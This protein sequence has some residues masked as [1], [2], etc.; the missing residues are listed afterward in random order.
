MLGTNSAR[1]RMSSITVQ[2]GPEFHVNSLQVFNHSTPA[3][4]AKPI[5]GEFPFSLGERRVWSSCEVPAISVSCVGHHVGPPANLGCELYHQC[6]QGTETQKFIPPG[7]RNRPLHPFPSLRIF[8]VPLTR[9]TGL[10]DTHSPSSEA[11][12]LP[13]TWSSSLWIE[14]HLIAKEE[15]AAFHSSWAP[16]DISNHTENQR[17]LPYLHSLGSQQEYQNPLKEQSGLCVMNSV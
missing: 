2:E 14:T 15:T 13:P 11:H 17:M 7:V 9:A 1:Y 3:I 5:M 6:S 10:I 4:D 8:F 16:P 12:E